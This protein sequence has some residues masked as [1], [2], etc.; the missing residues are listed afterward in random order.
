MN[1]NDSKTNNSNI[2]L[3]ALHSPFAEVVEQLTG[4]E[5]LLEDPDSNST[6][7]VESIDIKMPLELQVNADESGEV[8]IGGSAPTQTIETTVMPVFHRLKLHLTI[9]RDH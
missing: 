8:S 4:W 9:D 5:D 2:N 3:H 1:T 7:H 6:M